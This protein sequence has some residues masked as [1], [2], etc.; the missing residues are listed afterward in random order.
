MAR[1][2]A[3]TNLLNRRGVPSDWKRSSN[4]AAN[5]RFALLFIDLDRFKSVNDGLGHEAGDSVLRAIVQLRHSMRRCRQMRSLAAGAVT[6]SSSSPHP[7]P[8][9]TRTGSPANLVNVA[10]QPIIFEGQLAQVGASIGFARFPDDATEVGALICAADLAAA[11]AK[12]M[13]RSEDVSASTSACCAACNAASTSP[14]SCAKGLRRP[15]RNSLSTNRRCEDERTRSLRGVVE[16]EPQPSRQRLAR[17]VHFHRRGHGCDRGP[18]PLDP[19]ARLPGG[20]A[21]P[22]TRPLVALAVNVS[23][24]QIVEE[25]WLGTMCSRL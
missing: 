18:G 19:L 4:P 1:R 12:R 13:G 23:V 17:R 5:S 11:E 21:W 10:A 2:D 20:D 22:R 3:L 16:N 6:S 9:P 14:L 7:T 8:I 25:R 24:K 15:S